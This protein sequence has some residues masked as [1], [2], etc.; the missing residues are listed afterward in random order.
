V[1]HPNV[2]VLNVTLARETELR[3][4]HRNALLGGVTVLQGKGVDD[5]QNPVTLTAVPY[6]AWANREE[7]AM[8]IWINEAPVTEDSRANKETK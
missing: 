5:R 4:E 6:Y 2:N 1:D 7:G 8:T 3:A